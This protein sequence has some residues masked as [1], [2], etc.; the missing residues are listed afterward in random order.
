M[1]HEHVKEDVNQGG[2][3]F[4]KVIRQG[5]EIFCQCLLERWLRSGPIGRLTGR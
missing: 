2:G 1:V 5:M 3:L 4:D